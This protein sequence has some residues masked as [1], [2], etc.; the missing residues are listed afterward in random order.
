MIDI[1]RGRQDFCKRC[2][3]LRV[4]MYV[5]GI[6]VAGET[7]GRLG[8]ACC[9]LSARAEGAPGI[10]AGWSKLGYMTT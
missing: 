5:A 4:H 10:Y 2:R 1:G 3:G 9:A 7:D 8:S 6:R